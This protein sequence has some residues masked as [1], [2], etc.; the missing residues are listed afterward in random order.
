MF[1]CKLNFRYE[2]LLWSSLLLSYV[3]S[4]PNSLR[5]KLSLEMLSLYWSSHT[6]VPFWMSNSNFGLTFS[7]LVFIDLTMGQHIIHVSL[8]FRSSSNCLFVLANIKP[9]IIVPCDAYLYDWQIVFSKEY[10]H[11][12]VYIVNDAKKFV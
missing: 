4:W 5:S 3:G 1:C 6:V 7:Y 10:Y 11:K 12:E 8:V 2:N 9:W